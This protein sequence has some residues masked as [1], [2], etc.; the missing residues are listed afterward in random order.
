[1]NSLAEVRSTTWFVIY[2]GDQPSAAEAVPRDKHE[3]GDASLLAGRLP[4]VA[5]VA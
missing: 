2:E 1:M 5:R 4:S 3:P